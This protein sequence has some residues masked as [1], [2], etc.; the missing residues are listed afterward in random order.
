MTK[1]YV[2]AIGLDPAVV[3]FSAFPQLTPELVR[4]YIDAQITGLRT[5]GFDVESCL[6]DLGETAE[7][8]TAAALSSKQY[9][10]VVIGAGLR[11]PPERLLLFEK[12]LNLVHRLAPGACI[13]FNSNPAD[14]AAAVQR[15]IKP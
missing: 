10:C 5:L 7:A 12:I 14:T 11:E 13:C 9:D 8:V 4:T 6:I 15:W 1:R 3:D 2:L